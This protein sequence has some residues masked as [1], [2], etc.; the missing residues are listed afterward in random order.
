ME[1]F[2]LHTSERSGSKLLSDMI[3]HWVW[4]CKHMSLGS[5]C[6]NKKLLQ[7]MLL[8]KQSHTEISR[9]FWV[10]RHPNGI[11]EAYGFLKEI[12]K[13]NSPY[14]VL[15]EKYFPV[16]YSVYLSR[17]N[18]V[19]QA[20][21]L[22]KARQ[23]NQYRFDSEP[24]AECYYDIGELRKII[25]EL[26]KID[27]QWEYY[28]EKLGVTPYRLYYEDMIQDI[29]GAGHKLAD[30]FG[31]ER[32]TGPYTPYWKKQADEINA[33]WMERFAG[34]DILNTVLEGSIS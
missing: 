2:I 20:I 31:F 25:V 22:K 21:S 34:D 30:H 7:S 6:P 15:L 29:Q 12:D 16:R 3:K 18:K 8:N 23:T 26:V 27:H 14:K 5:E 4:P 11:R 9:W 24:E 32:P 1:L 13:T 28:F 10:F 17:R 19:L 33:Q